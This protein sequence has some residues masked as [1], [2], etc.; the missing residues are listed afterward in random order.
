MIFF[1]FVSKNILMRILFLLLFLQS[2]IFYAQEY[3]RSWSKGK[4]TWNDFKTKENTIKSSELKYVFGYKEQKKKVNDTIIKKLVAYG[5]I[6]NLQ[7]WVN[8][9]AKN[10][11]LLRYNQLLFDIVEIQRREFQ[12]KLNNTNSIYGI[13]NILHNQN[14][15]LLDEVERLNHYSNFGKN[16]EAIKTW[17]SLISKKLK[18]IV[19]DN[20]F[21]KRNF[22]IGISLGL[23]TSILS[24]NLNTYFKNS[25][26]NFN[27]G[28]D[29]AYKKHYLFLNGIMG[30]TKVSKE[31]LINS[32]D[33]KTN[34]N[35][36]FTIIDFSYGY[37]ILD[38]SK[39]KLTPFLGLGITEFSVNKDKELRLVDYNVLA[40]INLYYK[41]KKTLNLISNSSFIS[42]KEYR[43]S[44]I[45]T[46]LF[47]NKAAFGN[48]LNG[49]SVNISIGIN[50]FVHT[51]K[52]NK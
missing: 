17:E 5:N 38:H 11:Q 47:I 52:Y 2:S 13:D 42:Q 1:T 20:S 34:Q 14:T 48:F 16:L 28:F 50:W 46:R 9:K 29:F 4:L 32:Q 49:Y 30:N 41:Y 25:L 26:I 19:V 51:L 35:T 3:G 24:K 8:K 43:E 22:G 33:W 45:S 6:D 21:S 27:F 7:S 10:S 23:S 15:L 37:A 18:Q 39:I 12:N 36:N 40:G 31:L 44:S